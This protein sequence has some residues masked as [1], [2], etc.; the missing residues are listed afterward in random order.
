LGLLIDTHCHLTSAGLCEQ[1]EA[2]LARAAAAGIG[3]C[4]TVGQDLADSA[5]ALELAARQ[6]NVSVVAGVHPHLAARVAEGWDRELAERCRDPRVRAVGETGL[7]Y[8]YDFSDRASQQRVFRRQL[9]LAADLGRP[10]VIHCREAHADVMAA[11]A[12]FPN[13]VGVVFHCYSGTLDQARELAARGYW[14]SLTGVLTFKKA[15]ELR[16]VAK[17]YP[18]DRIMLE[19]DAP[20]LSPEPVRNVRPNEPALLVHT[21]AR[22]AE[23]RGLGPAEAAALT[24]AN[25]VRFFGLPPGLGSSD[26]GS[27]RP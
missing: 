2:V 8:H 27:N 10:V 23:V 24:T 11:L 17:W 6:A 7:D 5:A 9:A 4:L 26:H 16:Q 18:A 1:A 14:I 12:E 13:L 25:A 19:T 3:H 21:A 15:E 22:L 20:Y